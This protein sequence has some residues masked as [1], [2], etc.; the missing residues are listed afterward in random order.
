MQDFSQFRS[1]AL[2]AEADEER[3]TVNTRALI[4]GVLARYPGEWTTLRELIQ[5]AAD[6]QA[7]KVSIQW[8]TLPTQEPIQNTSEPSELLKRIKYH[9]LSELIVTNNGAPFSDTDWAR[10]K[11]IAQGNP[12]E[13]KIGAFGVGFYSVFADCEEPF[14]VS[15]NKTM[16]FS[17]KD[18][19]LFTQTRESVK[20]TPGTALILKYRNIETQVPNLLSV[21]QFLAT[22][23][24]AP[25]S[26]QEIELW[27]DKYKVL[28]LRKNSLP[29]PNISENQ[30]LLERDLGFMKLSS[31]ER[32]EIQIDATAMDIVGW[33]PEPLASADD[34]SLGSSQ[35]S[36]LSDKIWSAI[37][38]YLGDRSLESTSRSKIRL[39]QTSA[40]ITTSLNE[41]LA[42]GLKRRTKKQPPE[43]TQL[44]LLTSLQDEIVK[45]TNSAVSNNSPNVTEI[46]ASILPSDKLGGRIFIGFPTMQ[47]TGAGMH[48]SSSSFIPTVEREA[49]DLNAPPVDDWNIKLLEVAGT[50]SCMA[51]NDAMS[52]LENKL[53]RKSNSSASA[54]DIAQFLPEALSLLETYTF[55][56]ST[57]LLRVAWRVERAFWAE[58]ERSTPRV[59]SSK[60]VLPASTVRFGSDEHSRFVDGIP[61]ILRS[62][63]KM[64]FIEKVRN[65]SGMLQDI[66]IDDV[67]DEL[68]SKPLSIKQAKAFIAWLGKPD[69]SG[70]LDANKTSLLDSAVVGVGNRTGHDSTIALRDIK[71]YVPTEI[72][73]NLP[74]PPTCLPSIFTT[75]TSIPYLEAL[76]WQPLEIV[77]WLQFL[78]ASESD[79]E[80]PT[81][82]PEVAIKILK[83]LS[84]KWDHLSRSLK[85][86][87]VDTLKSVT[88]IPT[89]KGMKKPEESYFQSVT[90]FRDLPTVYCDDL[91]ENLL[92]DLGVRKT[93]C[94]EMIF[95][96]LFSS[97]SKEK[98]RQKWSHMELIKY[99]ASVQDNIP[100][101]DIEKLKESPRFPAEGEI[102]LFK[103][104]ELFEPDDRLRTLKLPILQWHGM[105]GSYITDSIEARFLSCLGLR[106]YPSVPELVNM[107]ASR[108]SILRNNARQ[109]FI[110]YYQINRYEPL[111]EGSAREAILPMPDN[112]NILVPP[113]TCCTHGGAAVLGYNIL[114]KDLHEHAHKFR[115]PRDPPI[116]DC[117]HRLVSKPPLD[118][119]TAVAIFEYFTSRLDELRMNKDR[120]A[121]LRDALIVPLVRR[122]RLSS[123]NIS[124]EACYIG[125]SSKYGPI[126][127]FVDFGKSANLFLSECGAKDQP[128]ASEIAQLVCEDPRRLLNVLKSPRKYI[129]LLLIPLAKD[130]EIQAN[131]ELLKKMQ[132]SPFLL[133][134]KQEAPPENG[135]AVLEGNGAPI[136]NY[137]LAAPREIVI[138]DD[139]VSYSLFKDCLTCAP[140]DDLLEKLYDSLGSQ[141]LSGLVEDRVKAGP[142]SSDQAAGIKLMELALERSKI[143]LSDL[144]DEGI[145]IKHDTKWLEKHL[146]I[147]VVQSVT[148]HLSLR[149]GS[150]SRL[151]KRSA[152]CV[153]I[154]DEHILY[155]STESRPDMYQV[156]QILC[157]LLLTR[158]NQQLYSH[159]ESFL[160]ND[161]SVLR[162]RGY[163]VD[164]MLREKEPEAKIPEEEMRK[165]FEDKQYALHKPSTSPSG[166]SADRTSGTTGFPPTPPASADIYTS[167]SYNDWSTHQMPGQS[168]S[169]GLEKEYVVSSSSSIPSNAPEKPPRPSLSSSEATFNVDAVAIPLERHMDYNMEHGSGQ[170]S[171]QSSAQA[172][173]DGNELVLPEASTGKTIA[174]NIGTA[175]PKISIQ[176]SQDDEPDNLS[177][178]MKAEEESIHRGRTLSRHDQA[179]RS[180]SVS[181]SAQY[182]EAEDHG[183]SSSSVRSTTA[184]TS[185]AH[186]FIN[187]DKGWIT[188]PPSRTIFSNDD[189]EDTRY[190]GELYV[191]GL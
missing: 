129:D 163:N 56:K 135:M 90:L 155:I 119:K 11:C 42:I 66:S 40:V 35:S 1:K 134:W 116:A 26:L 19:A 142:N 185:Y 45:P 169:Y 124:P 29:V 78:I 44:T 27:I 173:T 161:L 59:Y 4:D 69:E 100:A 54:E 96:R 55:T 136:R 62:M 103:L 143:F 76:G 108:D 81:K 17:W 111:D 3:V 41:Q 120:L 15:G 84:R 47:T 88:A 52:N 102:N 121:S 24:L 21:S 73:P 132:S 36:S 60:G 83:I 32:A 58:Y 157:Q 38:A 130:A 178:T 80:N 180:P 150:K 14:V 156:A 145:S 115:V 158:S 71:H 140:E 89:K 170:Q 160:V 86:S 79:K 93:V 146:R 168:S 110:E 48:I 30:D 189:T 191:N 128:T 175:A 122:G 167:R 162:A 97:N 188:V 91:Q 95:E 43:K 98:R 61:V 28:T 106:K 31:V 16:E 53:K 179:S 126:F 74:I 148:V 123:A 131:E 6:A 186:S 107:M 5:N 113:S 171:S 68:K 109:Y 23:L 137:I 154:Y 190:F 99:L 184:R 101:G 177:T 138:L 72:P 125:N 117:I 46:F 37:I 144:N 147:E 9:K 10:L 166:I 22:C 139:M 92:S 104:S 34:I 67:R 127:D 51:F 159:F 174:G 57:P 164:R 82:S 141:K 75:S 133:G 7:T 172:P 33:N 153:H 2:G 94:L 165:G 105:L 176:P 20:K 114:R 63:R 181:L 70:K 112:E 8:K 39:R 85:D 152:A 118:S 50:M 64:Q 77:P 149:G 13:S 18:D 65:I 25:H 12:D 187:M 183:R 151:Q 182:I 49:L 87:V